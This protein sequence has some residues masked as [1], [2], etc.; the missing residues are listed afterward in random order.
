M[1]THDPTMDDPAPGKPDTPNTEA[2]ENDGISSKDMGKETEAPRKPS[3]IR[4]TASCFNKDGPDFDHSQDEPFPSQVPRHVETTKPIIE[5]VTNMAVMRNSD[6]KQSNENNDEKGKD[7]KETMDDKVIRSIGSSRIIIHSPH[8][9]ELIRDTVD[10]YPGQNLTGETITIHE[11]YGVLMHHWETLSRT[12]VSGEDSPESSS[13]ESNTNDRQTK[14]EHLSVLVEYLT[15]IVKSQL[16]PIQRRLGQETPTTTW[17][18]L[19]YLLR[20]GSQSYC[21]W[22][23]QWMGC[24]IEET[25]KA[26]SDEDDDNLTERW[27]VRIWF[28]S[29][30]W[31]YG[32]L[33]PVSHTIE[34][35]KFEGEKKVGQLDI[36]PEGYFKGERKK[37][38]EARGDQICD[39]LWKGHIYANYD[40][41][42]MSEKKMKQ[43]KGQ[44]IVISAHVGNIRDLAKEEVPEAIVS[45]EKL[46]I[47]KALAERQM[48][49]KPW[50]AD[51]IK[52]KGEGVVIL[53]HG[54]PGVGKTYTVESIAMRKRQ[55]LISL[56]IS[57][58]RTQATSLEEEL[59]RWFKMAD[60][61]RAILLIDE[62]DIFLERREKK[63][64]ERNAVVSEYFGGL[65][66]LTTNRVGHIDDAFM[67]RVHAVIG[68]DPLD[69]PRRE[70]IWDSLL[71][72][73]N[74]DRRGEIRIS[75][76]AKKFLKTP[77]VLEYTD[78][79][80]REIRNAF[81]T[82][83][84]LAEYEAKDASDY[85]PAQEVIVEAEQFKDVMEMNK[86]FR[87]YLDSIRS[88]SASERAQ[89][90]AWRNDAW[91]Q[92]QREN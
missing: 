52:N 66:F 89:R 86:S 31:S 9:S 1:S 56:T 73:L 43:Y 48:S 78:W 46:K 63:D 4:Y 80:G 23:G 33:I 27:K 85:D 82:A 83:I 38:F 44:I 7:K 88:W 28:L 5:I 92:Q 74:R 55:P 58:L 29:M 20:P 34:I 2:I 60:K 50:S 90:A 53:L 71:A 70:K 35:P 40:G 3:R 39:M 19:W 67:S 41:E 76:G 37:D 75:N 54:P 32:T 61:W 77:E 14:V 57:D 72:K 6:L 62:C 8:L 24:I 69:G 59:T 15:P 17:E 68:F 87:S 13:P 42:L 81:Q 16:E 11:P 45:G 91:D 22:K 12:H 47:I 25:R 36:Y 84:A 18:D 65:L 30:Q 79:N 49:A 21:K 64:I 26:L 10:Y 51:Y